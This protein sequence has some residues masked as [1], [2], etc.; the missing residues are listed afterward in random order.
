MREGK[1]LK[2]EGD[3]YADSKTGRTRN[4]ESLSRALLYFEASL[5][6]LMNAFMLEV[7]NNNGKNRSGR[8]CMRR[9]GSLW[10][11][12]VLIPSRDL[13]LEISITFL[14]QPLVGTPYLLA[15]WFS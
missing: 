1:R 4:G 3:S 15:S 13:V 14:F 5:C 10:T 12:E 8:R 9:Q 11:N 6:F 7:E 2:H